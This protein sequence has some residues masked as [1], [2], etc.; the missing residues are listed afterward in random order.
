M[1]TKHLSGLPLDYAVA[2]AKEYECTVPSWTGASFTALI[3]GSDVFFQPSTDMWGDSIIDREKISTTVDHSGVWIAFLG[4]N[5]ADEARHMMSGATR[6]EAA[7]R[8][9]VA[10]KLGDEVEI[11]VELL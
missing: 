2:R 6:R 5:Y 8:C 4:A 10:S 9:F 11:P 7:M 3:N 1:K